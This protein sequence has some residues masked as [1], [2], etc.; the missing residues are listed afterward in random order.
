MAPDAFMP[1]ES[2]V[3][4]ALNQL[5]L[6]LIASAPDA[7]VIC[8]A[9]GHIMLVNA[10]VEQWFGYTPPEVHGQPLTVL[11]PERF[12]SAPLAQWAHSLVTPGGPSNIAFPLA[13]RRKDGQEFALEMS[14]SSLVLEHELF[15]V[16]ILRDT[17]AYAQEAAAGQRTEL[18]IMLGQMAASVSHEIRNPLQSLSL[19]IELLEEELTPSG[20]LAEAFADIKAD[21]ARVQNVVEDY[22]SL[23]RVPNVRREPVDVGAMLAA[24]AQEKQAQATAHGVTLHVEGTQTLGQ[25][26]LHLFTMRRA[27]LNL[28]DNTLDAMPDGGHLTLARQRTASHLVLT[29][30]DTGMGIAEEALS[31]LFTPLYTTKVGG[32]GLG[33]YVVQEIVKAHAGTVEVTSTPERGTTFTLHLPLM[34]DEQRVPSGTV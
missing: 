11:L 21:L 33:L 7:V 15:V 25:A 9:A 13:G 14:L 34:R 23:A 1:V 2:S 4:H 32:T 20:P 10:Q 3:L 29:V 26:A 22:L 30:Q 12:L 19:N 8:N 27:V 28:V 18:L 16:S 17:A 31:R 24:I 6:P 5:F